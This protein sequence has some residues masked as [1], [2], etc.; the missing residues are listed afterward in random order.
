MDMPSTSTRVLLIRW[1]SAIA[2]ICSKHRMP[3]LMV[4]RLEYSSVPRPICVIEIGSP[5]T[6]W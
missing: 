5:L 3:P 1:N 6:I 4:S 2:G